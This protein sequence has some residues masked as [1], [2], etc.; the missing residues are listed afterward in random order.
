MNISSFAAHSL[1]VTWND[2]SLNQI[3]QPPFA[4][5]IGNFSCTSC[6]RPLR[7]ERAAALLFFCVF[8]F[9]PSW[10]LWM[11]CFWRVGGCVRCAPVASDAHS[12]AETTGC[13][14]TPASQC[15]QELGTRSGILLPESSLDSAGGLGWGQ[16]HCSFRH[17]TKETSGW[18]CPSC[19]VRS[20]LWCHSLIWR[21]SVFSCMFT[22]CSNENTLPCLILDKC[23][24]WTFS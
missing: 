21:C 17:A 5:L 14:F 1:P 2:Y 11:E 10:H 13:R 7:R 3:C 9:V 18:V 4:K 15:E 12:L 6:G 8:L 23:C 16:A 20:G 19:M 24:H 22:G